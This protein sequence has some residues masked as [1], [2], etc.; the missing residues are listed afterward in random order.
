[1]VTREQLVELLENI[2]LLLELQG[3]NPFKIRAYRSA[4][5]AAASYAGDILEDAREGRLES[6]P[7]IGQAIAGKI[8]GFVA[9]GRLDY[10]DQ[11]RAAYP[12]SLFELFRLR[13]LGPR[14]IKALHESLRVNSL[15]DLKRVCASGEASGLPGFGA[16]TCAKI[17]E[18][19][20]FLESNAERFRLGDVL[21]LAMALRESLREHPAALQ[22]S[23]AGSVR[24]GCETVHDLDF[25]VA[26]SSPRAVLD[27]FTRR[28][29]VR[30]ILSNGETKASVLLQNGL[31]CDL[32]AVSN[33]E[34]PFAL[35]YFTGSKEHNVALR[36][37]ARDQGFT[38]NEYRLAPL[39]DNGPAPPGINTEEELY[40]A[41]GLP[42]ID[43]A[44]RE[45]AGEFEAAANGTLPQL[46]RQENLRGTF[47]NHTTASD[48]RSSLQE[49]AEAARDLGL[50]YLGIA[51]HS[52]SSVQANGLDA[53][54]LEAQFAEIQ[55]LNKSFD[56]FKLFAG[57]ECDILRDGSL[58]FDDHVLSQLDYVV[59][60]VHSSFQLSEKDQTERILRAVAN[61]YV[62]ILG[63]PT[64]RLLLERDPYAL[65]LPAVIDACADTGTWIELNANPWRL[66][67]DWRWW[68]RAR[69]RGVRCA[70]NPDAHHCSGLQD[71]HFGL[72]A[73]R[74][75]W[76]RREDVVNC[77][78]IGDV[79]KALRLK[80]RA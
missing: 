69:D 26:T 78:P 17:L 47:H 65:D 14:K 45:N 46:V 2:A 24:R 63:H 5:A 52:R 18:S 74:K 41:L 51:D 8:A 60:S 12:D 33:R 58:D 13:G 20:A 44:L 42:W 3:E 27:A 38:L 36:G 77:L 21:P 76:L 71:L 22:V 48:G 49:M 31:Q 50:Q 30:E 57:V 66:D 67:L 16:K 68:R 10:Y 1:M 11:L 23:E 53:K 19:I 73:A 62:T 59:A 32:R 72:L 39:E 28:Q 4:A 70:I 40:G 25:I 80:R 15:E 61:P 9:S 43:P 64:G 34:Y 37:R 7:G 29:E 35:Q 6:I 54:R 56:G 55:L 79:E 75:G